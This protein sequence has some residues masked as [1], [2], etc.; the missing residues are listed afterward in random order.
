MN[1]QLV[2]HSYSK[3]GTFGILTFDDFKLHTVEQLWQNNAPYKSC[4]PC[5]TYNLEYYS[6][7]RHGDSFI[8]SS[9]ECNVG[10]FKGEHRRF[11]CLIH[12]ANFADQLQGCIAPG[13]SVG[14]I[15]DRLAVLKSKKSIIKMLSVLPKMEIHTLTITSSLPTF[16][17]KLNELSNQRLD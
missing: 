8:L 15:D 7:Q 2:R 17:E 16:E 4:I 14:M 6:S 9:D 1:I 11:G 5:G 3:F 12:A 10:K 13:M